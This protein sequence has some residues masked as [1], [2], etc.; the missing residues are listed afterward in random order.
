M[1]KR[2]K[3]YVPL[4]CSLVVLT[5]TAIYMLMLIQHYFASNHNQCDSENA[6]AKQLIPNIETALLLVVSSVLDPMLTNVTIG[7]WCCYL[8]CDVVRQKYC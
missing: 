7:Y 8:F 4:A 5:F 6:S 2:Q 3:L 1:L